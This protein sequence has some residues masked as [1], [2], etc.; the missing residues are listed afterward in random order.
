MCFKDQK[1]SGVEAAVAF[2]RFWLNISV[3]KV[4]LDH[5]PAILPG[6]QGKTV[7]LATWD[8]IHSGLW[9]IPNCN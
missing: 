8:P 3:V 7:G 9:M 6:S 1:L 5:E 2:F 4:S